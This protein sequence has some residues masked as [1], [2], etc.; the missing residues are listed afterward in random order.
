M[1]EKPIIIGV[2][3]DY[4]QANRALIALEHAGFDKDQGGLAATTM[5]S[6][7]YP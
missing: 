3:P 6:P 1:K 7:A 4:E 5:I 2:F